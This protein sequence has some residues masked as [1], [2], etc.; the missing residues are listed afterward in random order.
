MFGTT[1][2]AHIPPKR[3]HEQATAYYPPLIFGADAVGPLDAIISHK[4]PLHLFDDVIDRTE[5]PDYLPEAQGG[6]LARQELACHADRNTPPTRHRRWSKDR[7]QDPSLYPETHSISVGKWKLVVWKHSNRWFIKRSVYI[8]RDVIVQ[9]LALALGPSLVCARTSEEAKRIAVY[10]HLT[11]I[12][13]GGGMIWI[14]V[15]Q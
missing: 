11:P 14:N 5:L 3:T 13:A 6:L 15:T 9:E 12:E 10:F 7:Y 4:L 2:M 1:K 8:R